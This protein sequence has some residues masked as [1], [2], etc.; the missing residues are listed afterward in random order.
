MLDSG[1]SLL[2]ACASV[3]AVL[4]VVALTFGGLGAAVAV[5]TTML[6]AAVLAARQL[7]MGFVPFR[8]EDWA[9]AG[10]LLWMPIGFLKYEAGL[11]VT[12][13][14][15]STI[16]DKCAGLMCLG[17]AAHALGM[18]LPLPRARAG[19]RCAGPSRFAVL[20][21]S[22]LALPVLLMFRL[23]TTVFGDGAGVGA[24]SAAVALG[25]AIMPAAL[26]AMTVHLRTSR[27]STLERVVLWGALG[28]G[29]LVAIGDSSRRVFG[30][31]LFGILFP[32]GADRKSRLSGARA[33]LAVA[34]TLV[35]FYGVAT[36][37]RAVSFG[38]GDPDAVLADFREAGSTARNLSTLED[39]ALCVEL[40]PAEVP[41]LWGASY[42]AA[43]LTLV[44]REYWPQKPVAFSKELA[45]RKVLT[46]GEYEY[47]RELDQSIRFQSYSGT[48][49]GEAWANFGILGVT[50]VPLLYGYFVA[51]AS[52]ALQ[53][54]PSQS[55]VVALAGVAAFTILIQNR[56]C[57]TAANTTLLAGVLLAMLDD[58]LVRL[59]KAR[60]R[61]PPTRGVAAV[62]KGGWS[63]GS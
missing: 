50:L 53:Q 41:H 7:T 9:L 49:V 51:V 19:E 24:V 27:P 45:V 33:V 61:S 60:R 1:K 63:R 28:A 11:D 17:L 13:E 8:L 2:L 29:L 42:V 44:P 31:V 39:Y 55:W 56:G 34:V 43:L 38:G 3:S 36:L 57:A 12:R 40:Y 18:A 20:G 48:M 4:G 46:T 25:F 23:Q 47:S 30:A 16:I 21:V 52:R 58:R 59:S 14:V 10:F 62:G 26:G 5:A 35:V 22:L 54:A 37:M 32:L 6:L 15:S